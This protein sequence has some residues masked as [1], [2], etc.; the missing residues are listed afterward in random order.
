M[1]VSLDKKLDN[2]YTTLNYTL[3]F[4]QEDSHWDVKHNQTARGFP[5][6]AVEQPKQ[7][8]STVAAS[9]TSNTNSQ[10]QQQQLPFQQYN[11]PHNLYSE[12]NIQEVLNQQ[13]ETLATGVKG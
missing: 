3:H 2:I 8:G 4:F 12:A 5:G 9:A 13:T 1:C 10:Q 11:S 6:P 7:N